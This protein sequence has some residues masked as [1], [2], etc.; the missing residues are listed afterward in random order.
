MFSI[1]W[2]TVPEIN[3]GIAEFVGARIEGGYRGFGEHMS[4]AVLD[5]ERLVAGLVFHNYSPETGVIEFSAASS[6]ERWLTR[7]VLWAMFD[8]AFNQAKCQMV[9]MRVS[10]LNRT[11]NGRGIRRILR[12]YGFK[13]TR[14]DDL[15]GR[16]IAEM[17]Y[18]L[19][20]EAWASNGFHRQHAKEAR[21]AA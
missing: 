17:V 18:T 10:E 7:P 9:L 4:M 14:I 21:I 8:Y 2:G 3:E 16:G 13:E 12:A 1:A 5:G 6:S 19:T 20:D 15:R 11:W